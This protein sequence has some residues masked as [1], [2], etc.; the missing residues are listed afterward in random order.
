M[1]TFIGKAKYRVLNS[2]GI[3]VGFILERQYVDE[4]IDIAFINKYNTI[5]Y[6][7]N[8]INLKLTSNNIIRAKRKLKE[9]SLSQINRYKYSKKVAD[10]VLERDIQKDLLEWKNDK[11]H[12][13]LQLQGA[14]QI[15]KTTE[16]LKFAY[17]NYENVMYVNMANDRFNFKNISKT[18]N[19]K[20]FLIEYCMKSNMP[21]FSNSKNTLILIDEIQVSADVYNSIRKMDT[22]LNCDIIVTG[23]Y[24]GYTLNKEFFK[25]AGNIE[26]MKM[27]SMS[28]REF[29]RAYKLEDNIMKLSLQGESNTEDYDKLFEKYDI[30]KKIG[31]YPKVVMEY[32][33]T[34][35][36]SKCLSLISKL[37]RIFKNES[38]A[39]F[40]DNR[41]SIVFDNIYSSIIKNMCSNKKGKG[42]KLLKEVSKDIIENNKKSL[43]SSKEVGKAIAWL[44]ECDVLGICDLYNGNIEE[45]FNA[46]KL[47]F[48]DCGIANYISTI[49]NGIE[50]SNIDGILSENFAYCEFK[51]ICDTDYRVINTNPYFMIYNNY[52]LDF[53]MVSSKKNKYGIEIKTN[54][55]DD[56]SLKV[57]MQKN[58]L[59]Y[60]VLAEKTQGG[61]SNF[62]STK[63]IT[64][65]VFAVGARF[66]Y[67]LE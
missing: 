6:I 4:S 45:K 2:E 43:V 29:C 30:Y 35:N 52:E 37:I 53:V 3:T 59:D 27:L 26:Y 19:I 60:G 49:T 50:Q 57:I 32:I 36:I 17:K 63:T 62:S 67:G 22:E 51:N 42:S 46:R 58:M 24:L 14:R 16:L 23:S 11:G 65:P 54:K 7:K 8:I 47:Y 13:V 1:Q 31:G 39:Y 12:V 40:K 5:K 34:G 28:F 61:N 9:I 15:G 25:P 20:E 38:Q 44:V 33:N 18:T 21:K 10:N 41:E 48:M 66:P 56:K 64:I 55:G